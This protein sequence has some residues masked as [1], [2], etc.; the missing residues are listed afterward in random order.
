MP[1]KIQPARA[2]P[3]SD[4]TSIHIHALVTSLGYTSLGY[5]GLGYT[6]LVYTGLGYTGLG[7]T[8]LGYTGLGYT[9]LRCPG[10]GYLRDIGYQ[11]LLSRIHITSW[12][13]RDTSF[14]LVPTK[15]NRN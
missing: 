13:Q 3:R 6:G 8:G 9:G 5:T 1:P 15:S 4:F 14:S 11:T 7:Y 2:T 12:T 10:H